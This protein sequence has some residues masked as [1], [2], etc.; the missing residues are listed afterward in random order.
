[1]PRLPPRWPPTMCSTTPRPGVGCDPARK[2]AYR[3]MGARHRICRVPET[4]RLKKFRRPETEPSSQR[5]FMAG[6]SSGITQAVI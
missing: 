5:I 2:H 1:M 3:I 4:R 6:C